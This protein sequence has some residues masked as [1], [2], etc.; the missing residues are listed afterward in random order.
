MLHTSLCGCNR[1][2]PRLCVANSQQSGP[3]AGNGCQAQQLSILAEAGATA[4]PLGDPGAGARSHGELAPACRGACHSSAISSGARIHAFAPCLHRLYTHAT[5][6]HVCMDIN[7]CKELMHARFEFQALMMI[8]EGVNEITHPLMIQTTAAC[9]HGD[10][11][12]AMCTCHASATGNMPTL[13]A[14][15]CI[16]NMPAWTRYLCSMHA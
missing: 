16:Q 8:A 12:T 2:L 5:C 9:P 14:H 15:S 6:M 13:G 4:V 7:T 1:L 3:A 11:A 10:L